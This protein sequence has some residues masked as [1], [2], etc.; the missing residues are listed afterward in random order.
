MDG[1]E[2]N[3][4]GPQK[5]DEG[6]PLLTHDIWVLL[7]E[8]ILVQGLSMLRRVGLRRT[9]THELRGSS[10]RTHERRR[11]ELSWSPAV[12]I[13]T[14]SDRIVMCDRDRETENC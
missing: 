14:D 10:T 1:T 9:S 2:G 5:E 4:K 8:R 12:D 13:T 7:D 3:E 6:L 11:F